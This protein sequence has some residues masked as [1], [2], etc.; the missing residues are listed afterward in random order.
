MLDERQTLV[1]PCGIDCGRCE[2]YTARDIPAL[3]DHLVFVGIRKD[4]LPCDGCRAVEGACPVLETACETHSCITGRG[5]A[6]CYECG[7]FPCSRLN[8]AADRAGQLPHNTKVFNLCC[9][10]RQG[11]D[12][13]IQNSGDIRLRYF[14]GKMVIGKGPQID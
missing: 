3:L 2:C 5:L 14:T 11:L 7:D 4:R 6:F 1:A 8:P 10:E 9:I 12:T 13:F